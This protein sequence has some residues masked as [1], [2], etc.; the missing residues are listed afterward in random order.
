MYASECERARRHLS[1][2][3]G[4]RVA[5]ALRNS[6]SGRV[7]SFK[8]AIGV[9]EKIADGKKGWRKLTHIH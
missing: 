9:L 5:H 7:S 1:R 4:Y 2:T 8:E 6:W 3:S